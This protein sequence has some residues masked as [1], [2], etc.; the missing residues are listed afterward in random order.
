[1]FQQTRLQ[2][3][4]NEQYDRLVQRIWEYLRKGNPKSRKIIIDMMLPGGFLD[5]SSARAIRLFLAMN[6]EPRLL[7]VGDKQMWAKFLF[8][9]RGEPNFEEFKKLSPFADKAVIIVRYNNGTAHYYGNT[10][11]FRDSEEMTSKVR[12]A[13]RSREWAMNGK[14]GYAVIFD[15]GQNRPVVEIFWVGSEILDIKSPLVTER[16]IKKP[17][18][19]GQ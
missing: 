6:K 15:K 10:A 4:G 14:D 1:M 19:A 16:Q 18:M 2:F 8:E 11:A 17:A 3:T 7:W 12:R 13:L 5:M 9:M